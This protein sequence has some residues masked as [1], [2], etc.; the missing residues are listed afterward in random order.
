MKIYINL[1]NDQ[2]CK[3]FTFKSNN[4]KTMQLGVVLTYYQIW[5][6]FYSYKYINH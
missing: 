2:K 4:N 6:E 3:L 1:F 5:L